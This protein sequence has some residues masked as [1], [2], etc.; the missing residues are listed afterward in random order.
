MYIYIYVYIYILNIHAYVMYIRFLAQSRTPFVSNHLSVAATSPLLGQG[1]DR[2]SRA[3]TRD[4]WKGAEEAAEPRRRVRGCSKTRTYIYIYTHFIHVFIYIY[5]YTYTYVYMYIHNICIYIYVHIY[6]Y[7]TGM[8]MLALNPELTPHREP[9][10]LS[11]L[12]WRRPA[13]DA[14]TPPEAGAG[15]PENKR[16]EK[17]YLVQN[18]K[19][20]S[21]YVHTHNSK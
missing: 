14:P 11:L 9:Q 17:P 13:I 8:S 20:C 6:V 1:F 5:I 18:P 2:C 19:P 15:S 4:P 10:R 16:L 3:G 12:A 7:V 21:G